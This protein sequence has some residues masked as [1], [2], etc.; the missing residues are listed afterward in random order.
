MLRDTSVAGAVRF[1]FTDRHGGVSAAPYDELNLGGHVGDDP[2]AV[3]RNREVLATGIGLPSDAVTYMNQVHGNAVAVVDGPW[4]GP[5][6]EV[7]A[8]VTTE[9]DR[10]LAVLVADCVPVLLADPEAGVIAVA[11]AGRPGLAAG[12]VPAAI[13]A[14]RDLGARKLVARVGPA[15]CGR[16]YEVPEAMRAD[17]AAVVPEAWAVTRQGTPALDVPAG[18]VAQLRAAGAAVDTVATCTIEDPHSYSY[19]R[20]GVTGRFAG[21]AWMSQA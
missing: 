17:V 1:A 11:H 10:A 6:P 19:R 9:P 15:V 16:C 4:S 3:R 13:S 12:V 20:D 21:V 14:M 2:A 7:D 8:L 18:V 5:A